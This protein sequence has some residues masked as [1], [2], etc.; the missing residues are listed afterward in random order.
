MMP[1]T[2][3]IEALAKILYEK[4][5]HIDPSPGLPSWEEVSEIE[6]RFC[7]SCIRRLAVETELLTA[8]LEATAAYY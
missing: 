2:E 4:M 8:L 5:E 3:V 1:Q 7:R 6:R